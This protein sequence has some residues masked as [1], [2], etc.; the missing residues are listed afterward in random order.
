MQLTNEERFLEL[1]SRL[2]INAAAQTKVESLLK[3]KLDWGRIARKASEED[4][5]P[6]LFHNIEKLGMQDVFPF[7]L[8]KSWKEDYLGTSLRNLMFLEKRDKILK[9]F[10]EANIPAIVLKGAFLVENVYMN[11]GLRPMGD[12]DILI[13]KQDISVM[14]RKL[15]ELGYYTSFGLKD[16]EGF[17]ASTS[18]PYLNSIVYV[19][20]DNFR[21]C[22]NV[23]WHLAN[24]ITPLYLATKINMAR[25]WQDAAPFN[26]IMA[27]APHHLLIH[28]AEHAFRHCFNRTILLVDIAEVLTVYKDRINWEKF[29][30]DTFGFGLE[31]RVYYSLYFAVTKLDAQVP[32]DILT[33]LEPR[34]KTYGEKI[35]LSHISSNIRFEELSC[36]VSFFTCGRFRQKMRFLKGLTFPPQDVLAQAYLKPKQEI[37]LRD[38]FFRMFRGVRYI[39]K[40]YMN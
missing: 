5:T 24:S 4:I 3:G 8:Q 6:I 22:L 20:N 1:Y 31:R 38:Y 10:K 28:L 16:I 34:R 7:D 15:I 32:K 21:L 9:A 17:Q 11:L 18:S 12:V 29:L 13:K 36:F 23:H 40:G 2:T 37:N 33:V 14:H 27:M 26:N 30:R 19:K 35:F 25:I 39:A